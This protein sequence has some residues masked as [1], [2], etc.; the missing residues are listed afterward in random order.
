MDVFVQVSLPPLV[1]PYRAFLV[2]QDLYC[3]HGPGALGLRCLPL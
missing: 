2:T 3:L 1:G